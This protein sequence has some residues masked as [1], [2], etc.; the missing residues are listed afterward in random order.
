MVVGTRKKTPQATSLR[1]LPPLILSTFAYLVSVLRPPASRLAAWGN[2]DNTT[3]LNSLS[4]FARD[5]LSPPY[6]IARIDKGIV[7]TQ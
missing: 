5:A 4:N 7:F 6:T 3:S 1:W 2:M